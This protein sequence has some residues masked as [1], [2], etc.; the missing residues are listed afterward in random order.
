[1]SAGMMP[2]LD[3]PGEAI[4]GQFGPMIRVVFPAADAYAQNSAVSCTGT[5]SVITMTSG[6]RA[7]IASITAALVPAAGTNTTDTSAPVASIVS[8][9]VPNTGTSATPRSTGWPA[10][11]GVVPPTTAAPA[12]SIR[13]PCLR[14]SEP[15]IP[16]TRIRLSLVRKTAISR[17]R[18]GRGQLSGPSRR[19]VHRADLLDHVDP[20]LVQD[21]PPLGRLVAV[22]PHHDR[23]PHR[24]T[25]GAEHADCRHDAVGHRVARGDSA[26]DVDEDAAHRRVGQHDLQPVGHH[27]GRGAAA[28]V[29][30]VRRA[31]AAELLAGV[32][33][34]V[35]RGHDQPGAVADD[36]DLAV[37]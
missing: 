29:Q 14:P 27:L 25:A 1:M 10:L 21:A 16:W 15:V 36:A 23:V 31:H 26:E 13:R 12:W 11:R 28:D 6:M 24:L 18:S 33:H 22:Q 5:P 30:E 7:S 2:A 8:P 3:L 9:T 20:C 4:P 32:G 17:S 35:Q 37:Q 19:I 34:H